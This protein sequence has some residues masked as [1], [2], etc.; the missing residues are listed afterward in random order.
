MRFW[1]IIVASGVVTY[2]SRASFIVFGDRL[3]LPDPVERSLKYVAPAAFAAISI[4]LVLGQDGFEGF[5][6]DVPRI[7]AAL[8]AGAVLVWR[9]SL[10]LMLCVGMAVFWLLR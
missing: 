7:I 10:P 5:A 3:T 8:A 1:I 2:L 9:K 4:P 6:D